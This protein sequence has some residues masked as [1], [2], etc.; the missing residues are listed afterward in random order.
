MR[1]A[2]A[3]AL[4]STN[5]TATDMWEHRVPNF[6][7]VGQPKCATTALHATLR[8][9]HQIFLCEP[10]EPHFYCKDL[11]RE[12][13]AFHG[14]R[15]YFPIR[16]WRRYL[17]LF[18]GAGRKQIVGESS[19]T[20][21][22]SQEALTEISKCN[23]DARILVLLREPG[24]F[25]VSYHAQMVRNGYETCLDVREALALESERRN[26]REIPPNV[27]FPRIVFYREWMQYPV[28]LHRL[29]RLFPPEQIKIILYE[30]LRQNSEE[31]LRDIC[32]W[33]GVDARVRLKLRRA[34]TF[35]TGE[36]RPA[37]LRLLNPKVRELVR[38]VLPSG[39]PDP[40]VNLAWRLSWRRNHDHAHI[41]QD[42]RNLLRREIDAVVDAT[43]SL[44]GYDLRKIWYSS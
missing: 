8:Q 1:K 29:M 23:P 20:Y 6:F 39:P 35:G 37:V 9:H 44:L 36:P 42:V 11:H 22:F 3:G 12:S 33:L 4:T 25:L 26:G 15:R 14:R 41:V 21:L 30:Q 27:L 2:T 17:R 38:R 40:A 10:K 7:I 24:S 34:N 43:S 28:L 32:K 16:H 5:G 13:D 19:A 31:I 18:D